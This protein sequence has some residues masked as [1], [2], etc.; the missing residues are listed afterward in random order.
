M[1]GFDLEEVGAIGQLAD[2]C[3]GDHVMC[4]DVVAFEAD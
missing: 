2:Q 3:G 1:G 4:H